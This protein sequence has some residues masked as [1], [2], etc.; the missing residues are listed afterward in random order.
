MDERRK[1]LRVK[2]KLVVVCRLPEGT[3]VEALGESHNISTA[4]IRV[5]VP[6][7]AFTQHELTFDIHLMD[8]TIPIAARGK[9]VWVI[10]QD[11]ATAAS[12][13]G[14]RRSDDPI[15]L[16]GIEFQQLDEMTKQRISTYLNSKIGGTK[17]G[18]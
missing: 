17:K 9:V 10:L 4:G 12:K 7:G 11:R 2:D 3:T 8:D 16:M 13:K 6:H 15:R 5:S 18:A 1:A 14:A